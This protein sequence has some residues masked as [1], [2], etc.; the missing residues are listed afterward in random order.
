MPSSSASIAIDMNQLFLAPFAAASEAQLAMS[1]ANLK[2]VSKN[3]LDNSGNLIIVSMGGRYEASGGVIKDISLNIPLIMLLNTPSLVID[4][5][6]MDFTMVIQSQASTSDVQGSVSDSLGAG[7]NVSNGSLGLGLSKT[8][9]LGVIASE[10]SASTFANYVVHIE[11]NHILS[12]GMAMLFD[13]LNG[14]QGT[15]RPYGTG[16]AVKLNDLFT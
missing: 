5:V 3:G 6:T 12:P 14:Y 1:M 10:T 2:F 11:A 16:V 9:T 4:K 13:T 15:L 7:L 8:R